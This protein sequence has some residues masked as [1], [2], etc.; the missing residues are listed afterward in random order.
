MIKNPWKGPWL[1]CFLP[2]PQH[3][4]MRLVSRR[5]PPFDHVCLLRPLGNDSFLFIEWT[6]MGLAITTLTGA[7]ASV[8]LGDVA[9]HGA[10]L[11][12]E[13]RQR[14]PR[15]NILNGWLPST[16]VTLSRQI[17]GL[18]PSWRIWTPY[19]LWCEL[20]RRGGHALMQ[21]PEKRFP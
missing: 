21:P 18:P 13:V 14:L 15:P 1:V 19:S 10:L 16:C 6:L 5:K 2:G 17:L 20:Q 4:F 8:V 9:D 7:Q 12:Y 11:R 3:W